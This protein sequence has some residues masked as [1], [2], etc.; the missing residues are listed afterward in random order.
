MGKAAS[1]AL[2]PGTPSHSRETQL[3]LPLARY[4]SPVFA[5]FARA[6]IDAATAPS[7]LVLE[8]G[9]SDATCI[10]EIVALGRRAL[11]LNVNPIPLLWTHV[12]LNPAPFNDVQ[13]ALTRLGDLPKG[14]GPFIAH[15]RDL[16]HSH[17]PTCKATGTAEW[18][19]WDRDTQ[20]PFAKR[21]R[22]PRC[23]DVKEGN[24]D[25]QD[26]ERA[27]AFAPRTGPAY[28]IALGRAATLDDPLRERAAEL[29]ALYTPRNLSV[30]MDSIHRIPQASASSNVQRALTTLIVE[31]LDR[32][33]TDQPAR[34]VADVPERSGHQI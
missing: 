29:V 11:A 8:L 6:A 27:A 18:F 3:L 31:A 7:D 19:A 26:I 21:V 33:V 13:T 12:A 1:P 16:Y 5:T 22:C 14:T 20:R 25:A 30:L 4:R 32:R 34:N 28:H 17:C 2:I 23:N 9:A 24:V 10:R 15:V